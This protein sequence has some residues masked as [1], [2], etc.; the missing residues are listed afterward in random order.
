MI[1][2]EILIPPLTSTYVIVQTSIDIQY[3]VV[4]IQPSIAVPLT[5]AD[6]HADVQPSTSVASDVQP[7]TSVATNVQLSTLAA[8]DVQLS[9]LAASDVQPSTSAAA[10]IVVILDFGK[11]RLLK[12][13][14]AEFYDIFQVKQPSLEIDRAI[15]FEK[16]DKLFKKKTERW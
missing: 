6:V 10:G 11:T 13:T 2:P 3:T 1:K 4:D 12:H 9:T 14:Y 7:S 15:D 16:M 8:S 5:T